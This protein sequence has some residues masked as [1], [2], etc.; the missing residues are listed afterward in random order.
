MQR[1]RH[2]LLE[3]SRACKTSA[4]ARISF[5]T[6]FL[7]FQVIDSGCCTVAA[8]D[9][10]FARLTLRLLAGV[11]EIP[12]AVRRAKSDTGER[13]YLGP[14]PV[15]DPRLRSHSPWP[16]ARLSTYA[17]EAFLAV[18]QA[19]TRRSSGGTFFL[20]PR[21]SCSTSISSMS[22]RPFSI[23]SL[24]LSATVEAFVVVATAATGKL[25]GPSHVLRVPPNP[26]LQ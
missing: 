18:V 15:G 17:V 26:P 25:A 7:S 5:R 19:E 10:V 11:G 12:V 20:V 21:S 23:W 13:G 22:L 6:L 4:K 24:L 14:A 8:Q 9:S 2:A 3:L 16:G 1:R